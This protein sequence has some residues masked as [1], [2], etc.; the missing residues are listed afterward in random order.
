[1]LLAT[2]VLLQQQTMIIK[3][4]LLCGVSAFNELNWRTGSDDRWFIEPQSEKKI[5]MLSVFC[6]APYVKLLRR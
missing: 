6:G 5:I 2:V 1:M 4:P 3:L